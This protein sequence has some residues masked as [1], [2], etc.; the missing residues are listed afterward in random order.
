VLVAHYG[1]IVDDIG[2]NGRDELPTP[3]R[4]LSWHDDLWGPFRDVMIAMTLC[5]GPALA[6]V[7]YHPSHKPIVISLALSLAA[8]GTVAAPAALLTTLTS[9]T[10]LNA[11]PDRLFAVMGKCGVH[12]VALFLL[13]VA[14]FASYAWGM[15]LCLDM[16]LVGREL[17]ELL[18]IRGAARALRL[19]GGLPDL[20]TSPLFGAGMLVG[21]IFLIH[22]FCWYLG[23]IYRLHHAEFPWILQRH[24]GKPKDAT[25]G[26][27]VIRRKRSHR[28][29]GGGGVQRSPR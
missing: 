19:S 16:T 3:T 21:G 20:F 12:Y 15:I 24:I 7:F 6:M 9:G 27:A 5:Y 25:K 11:R 26:F 8:I 18:G 29:R 14:L 28:F 2:P 1:N 10:V 13:W 4:G 17:Y 23:I 22:Y